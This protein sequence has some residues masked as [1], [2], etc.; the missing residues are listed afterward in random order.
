MA[1]LKRILSVVFIVLVLLSLLWFARGKTWADQ[2]VARFL[3][4]SKD[5]FA[6]PAAKIPLNVAVTQDREQVTVCN[7][8]T[9]RWDGT[10]IRINRGYVAKMKSLGA[11]DCAR[12]KKTSFL[13]TDWKHLPA[14]RDLQVTEVE[15]LSRFSGMGYAKQ[16]VASASSN[17]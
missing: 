1:S 3:T 6:V 4:E 13:S 15:I 14:A 9:E 17:Q 2:F 16:Q 11:G 8:G 5:E 7:R 12:I 10:L